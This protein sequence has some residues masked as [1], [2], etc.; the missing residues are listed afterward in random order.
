M[1]DIET[2]KASIE[3]KGYHIL[4]NQIP[5]NDYKTMRELWLN[6]YKKNLNTPGINNMHK[7]GVILD[8]GGFM[9]EHV[10]G[11]SN[12]PK[13]NITF[14]LTFKGTDFDDGGISVIDK[15]NNEIKIDE[16][17]EPTDVAIFD[18]NLKHEVKKVYSSKGIG[19]IG[20][21]PI[22]IK[23]YNNQE[24]PHYLKKISHAHYAIK[25]RLGITTREKL[26]DES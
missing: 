16:I 8:D 6:Y 2:I 10:D 17:V 5:L 13:I 14:N 23:F 9:Y 11:Y 21:F 4:K 19:R 20:V 1:I 15:Q 25:R 22:V 24:I 12:T 26:P 18:G 7:T 3:D